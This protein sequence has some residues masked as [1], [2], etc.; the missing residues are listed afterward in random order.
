MLVLILEELKELKKSLNL[1]LS[2]SEKGGKYVQWAARINRV[3][4]IFYAVTVSLFL[5]LMYTEWN[6]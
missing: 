1:H 4:F 5:S 6:T 2:G 3:F